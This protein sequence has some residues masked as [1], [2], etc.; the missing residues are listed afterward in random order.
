MQAYTTGSLAPC[1]FP[2][3]NVLWKS[4][5]FLNGCVV[6]HFYI[7]IKWVSLITHK[8]TYYYYLH[9]T[10]KKMRSRASQIR[11]PEFRK[12]LK[13]YNKLP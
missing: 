12:D 6:L 7:I 4:F 2:S 10:N 1:F 9:F 13:Y 11:E 3:S 8:G 5:P